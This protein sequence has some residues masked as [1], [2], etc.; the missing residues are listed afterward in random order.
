MGT[1]M[2]TNWMELSFKALSQN[3]G[4]ARM[5]ISAFA[6]GANPTIGE[7]MDVKTAVSEGVTNAIV[8]GY[9]NNPEGVV[10]LKARLVEGELTV[11]II[12]LGKGIADVAKARE[13]FYTTRP[14]LE[15]TGMGFS[16]ME[17][18]MDSLAVDSTPHV[19]TKLTLKKYIKGGG[20]EEIA[21][22]GQAVGA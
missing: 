19:G 13:P 20:K 7:L 12:D 21:D 9:E 6:A 10:T 22:A 2:Q 18:F 1:R 5:V 15:R 14:E 3:E 17:S 8:H 16:V 11:E 4:F